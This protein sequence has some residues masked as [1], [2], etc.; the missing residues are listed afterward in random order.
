MQNTFFLL[1]LHFWPTFF[2]FFFCG[3]FAAKFSF[4]FFYLKISGEQES[5]NLKK[6]K[7]AM[8][9]KPILKAMRQ[10]FWDKHVFFSN[11]LALHDKQFDCTI[12]SSSWFV[13]L[14]QASQHTIH[15]EVPLLSWVGSLDTVAFQ[16]S[17]LRWMLSFLQLLAHKLN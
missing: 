6:K 12:V 17:P 14:V 9:K 8:I 13:G 2:F 7:N 5:K 4:F 15:T 16:E 1:L 3:S 10:I 11:Y